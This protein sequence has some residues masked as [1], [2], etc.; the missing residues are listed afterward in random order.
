[1]P[2]EGTDF[3]PSVIVQIRTLRSKLPIFSLKNSQHF[4]TINR[5]FK[6]RQH[7][8]T[9][10]DITPSQFHLEYYQ[11]LQNALDALPT[12][13]FLIPAAYMTNQTK[14]KFF[15]YTT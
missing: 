13:T 6:T 11:V 15:L 14:I 9:T 5:R 8:V 10:L 12:N 7:Q 1:M 4:R 2:E 3:P